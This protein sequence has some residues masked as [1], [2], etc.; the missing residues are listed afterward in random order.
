MNKK[1]VLVVGG[2]GYIGSHMVAA[3][4]Q[5]GYHTVVF[6][7]LS[8]G[9]LE[10]V[11]TEAL[12]IKGD[13]GNFQEIEAVFKSQTLNAVIHMAASSIVPESVQNP[14]KYYQNNVAACIPLLKLMMDH[15]VPH[16]IFSSTAAVYGNPSEIPL[17]EE[18]V[19]KPINPYGNSKL[20][21]EQMIRDVSKAFPLSYV[22][23]RYFNAAGAQ[24]NACRGEHHHPETHL[25]PNLLASMNGSNQTMT[26]YG[27]DYETKDGTCV[28]DFIH[29]EDLCDA[30]LKALRYLEGGGQSTTLNLGS[31][32][33][34]SVGE[35]IRKAEEITGR[36]AK[37]QI[38]E[39]RAGDPPVLVASA[40]KA[41]KVLGWN[42]QHPLDSI[43]QTAWRW[44]EK[45]H[46]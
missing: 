31:E 13:L 15:H 12:F 9:H 39:R 42:P 11:P 32:E 34:Y 10:M 27:N 20:M 1:S 2:A 18:A 45:K 24:G 28:R 22:V 41:R 36:K 26:L 19:T 46:E 30:H 40:Q 7:N 14:L 17:S 23:L 38:G 33:G 35:V 25:I 3:L 6:D 5:A 29:V 21:I 4:I 8:T 44:Y 37:I 16:M 43:L